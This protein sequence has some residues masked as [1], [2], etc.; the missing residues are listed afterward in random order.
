MKTSHVARALVCVLVLAVPSVGLSDSVKSYLSG[1]ADSEASYI[2]TGILKAD[3]EFADHYRA[4]AQFLVDGISAASTKAE[5]DGSTGATSRREDSM[6][7]VGGFSAGNERTDLFSK[8]PNF[9]SRRVELSAYAGADIKESSVTAGVIVSDEPLYKSQTVYATFLQ[10]FALRNTTLSATYFHNFDRIDTD[11]EQVTERY[12][13]PK[14][15]N[16]DGYILSLTQI[17]SRRTI[18]Q[19]T[20]TYSDYTG[21]LAD[22]IREVRQHQ[23]GGDVVAIPERL[24]NRR[25]RY[26]GSAR[27]IQYLW[28]GSSLHAGYR[29]YQDDWDI[30]SSTY[31]GEWFQ[32]L[33]RHVLFG[34]HGRYY[35]QTASDMLAF[36]VTP[37]DDLYSASPVME[38]FQSQL[39]GGRLQF[40]D[41]QTLAP[42]FLLSGGFKL[43]YY[44]QSDR[45]GVPDGFEAVLGSA[46]ILAEF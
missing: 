29:Y 9:D 2:V 4:G 37:E 35:T 24:P 8:T 5:T 41:R 34:F 33:G 30:R 11:D 10:Y 44:T 45:E 19:L 22:P 27:I 14:R 43:D 46:N 16:V 42:N 7:Y 23:S 32:Y 25:M 20:A 39:V 38:E 12:D 13:Y 18:G 1:Y 6:G 3:G 40:F 26:A 28:P 15:K 36:D 17:L 31:E 21:A